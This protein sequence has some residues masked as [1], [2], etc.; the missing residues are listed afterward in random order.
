MKIKV[1]R[2]IRENERAERIIITQTYATSFTL[3]K[4]LQTRVI[5][6]KSLQRK[7]GG[8]YP[9]KVGYCSNSSRNTSPPTKSS[10]NGFL[11]HIQAYHES[12]SQSRKQ[13]QRNKIP[14][15]VVHPY[16]LFRQK[17]KRLREI[18]IWLFFYHKKI[19]WEKLIIGSRNG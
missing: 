9:Q 19:V 12:D 11:N 1:N 18:L 8:R 10:R 6:N 5:F 3:N 15:E 17:S 14:A 2:E 7:R 4:Q 16:L 13:L